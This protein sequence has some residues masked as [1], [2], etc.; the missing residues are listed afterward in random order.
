MALCRCAGT[1][2]PDLVTNSA[3]G[4][5]CAHL[6]RSSMRPELTAFRKRCSSEPSVSQPS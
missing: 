5:V 6:H 1:T 3:H 2:S 4:H